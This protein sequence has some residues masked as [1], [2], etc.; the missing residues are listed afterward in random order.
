MPIESRPDGSIIFVTGGS[1]SGKT[2]YSM[3]RVARDRRLNVWDSQLQWGACGCTPVDSI[4]A[5]AELCATREPAHLA[6]QGPVTRAHFER[7]CTIARCWVMLSPAT[8]VVEELAG[9]SNPGKASPQ[10]GELVRT[11]RKYAGTLLVISHRPAETDKTALANAHQIIVHG[12]G[13]VDDAAYIAREIGAPVDAVLSLNLDRYERLE[14]T[15]RT[16]ALKRVTPTPS[17]RK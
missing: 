4:P 12:G 9:V 10:W 5:L 17:D 8:V 14:W 3:R 11:V 2:T 7:W 1:G 13:R 16:R 15:R 6:Y